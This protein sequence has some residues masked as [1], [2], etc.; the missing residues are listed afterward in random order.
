MKLRLLFSALLMAS[1]LSC[2]SDDDGD[3]GS[4][5]I[6]GTWDAVTLQ[7][8]SGSQEEQGLADLFN[9]LAAQECYLISMILEAD[10][11]A[12][13]LTSI[14]YLDLS[15]LFTGSLSIDCPTENDSESAT[16]TFENGQLRITDSNGMSISIDA[17]L[18]GDRLTLFLEGEEFDDLEVS[19]SL[20]F[21]RR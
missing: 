14:D 18:N 16:Y 12:T 4:N 11:E 17:T 5:S 13:L 20:V 3:S 2:S 8:D 6:E 10:N 15:G 19:G 7:L 1:L 21:E 9:L